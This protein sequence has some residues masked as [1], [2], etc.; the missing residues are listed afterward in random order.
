LRGFRAGARPRTACCLHYHL[1]RSDMLNY[2]HLYYFHVAAMERSVGAAAA[3]LGVKQPTVS[4][5]LRALERELGVTL[6]ERRSTGLT[7]SEAG[8]VAFEHTSVMFRVGDRL[9]HDLER[10]TKEHRQ[11]VRVGV[12]GAIARSTS[13]TFL[14]PLLELENCVLSIRL[15]DCP[16]LLRELRA[17]TL[18]LVL[19]ENTPPE[20]AGA[21]LEATLVQSA[22][23]VAIA[24]P[25]L[26][27]PAD[28]K[29]VPLLQFGT[30]AHTRGVIEEYLHDHELAPRLAAEADDATFL[31]EAAAAGTHLAIVPESVARAAIEAG[32]VRVLETIALDNA[33]VYAIH[34]GTT[35]TEL[36]RSA[37]QLLVDTHRR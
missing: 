33:G 23:L 30:G 11:M 34:R 25:A 29:D 15:V 20:P 16:D 19:C 36:A 18:D 32:R 9:L 28:W 5:Q 2:N 24:A 3:R 4:E 22:T 31:V 1:V 6:F 12:S 37:I 35:S 7:L 21:D 17:G 26:S 8:R 10:S 14:M 13:A 27:I